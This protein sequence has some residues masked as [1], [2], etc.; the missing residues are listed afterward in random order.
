MPEKVTIYKYSGNKNRLQL[1]TPTSSEKSQKK[2]LENVINRHHL[3]SNSSS[4]RL[5]IGKE[6]CMNPQ[7]M[8]ELIL[9]KK[10]AQPQQAQPQLLLRAPAPQ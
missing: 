5:V 4:S 2:E 7:A 6:E 3:H 9:R 8:R 1:K 10:H